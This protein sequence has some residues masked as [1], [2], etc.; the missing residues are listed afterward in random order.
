MTM[1]VR[2]VCRSEGAPATTRLAGVLPSARDT[3]VFAIGADGVEV[4][5]ENVESVAWY[6][7][8]KQPARACVTF[9]NAEID[10]EGL[11]E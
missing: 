7:G 10:A 11:V 8:G 5:L 3:H 6:V 9:V 2:I 4:E 1:R